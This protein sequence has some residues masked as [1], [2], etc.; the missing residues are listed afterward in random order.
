MSIRVNT[1]GSR[2]TVPSVTGACKLAS[3]SG[4][5]PVR[6]KWVSDVGA[7]MRALENALETMATS[8]AV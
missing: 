1:P 7:Q 5:G 4:A 3:L 8:V 2:P 6:A